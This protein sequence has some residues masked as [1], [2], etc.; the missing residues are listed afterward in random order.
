MRPPIDTLT[1]AQRA[2]L[3]FA[4]SDGELQ[5]GG[6][7]GRKVR[8]DVAERLV[9]LGLL[10]RTNTP[11]PHENWWAYKIAQTI[12]LLSINQAG[13]EQIERVRHPADL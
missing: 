8:R 12:E 1:A 6:L 3:D 5:I 13:A 10:V 11:T 2:A 9:G 7:D 4:I